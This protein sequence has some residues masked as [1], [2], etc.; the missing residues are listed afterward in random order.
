MNRAACFGCG[1]GGG[2]ARRGKS[3]AYGDY[4]DCRERAESEGAHASRSALSKNVS[5]ALT[6]DSGCS[7]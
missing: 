7:A 1:W 4:K 3:A 6:T 2:G 5:M